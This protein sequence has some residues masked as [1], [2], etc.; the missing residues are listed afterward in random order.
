MAGITQVL[1]QESFPCPPGNCPWSVIDIAG[2]SSYTAITPGSPPTGGQAISCSTL[3]LPA[4]VIW[5]STS[6]GSDD[7]TYK[8]IPM[9]SPFNAGAGS[10][11]GII[12]QWIVAATGAEVAGATNLSSRTVRILAIGR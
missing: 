3:G 4:S 1:T 8:A 9:L 10:R 7:G 5:A 12:L 2:P 11:T 6:M